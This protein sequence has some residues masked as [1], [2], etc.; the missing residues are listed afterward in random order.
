MKNQFTKSVKKYILR[1]LSRD[2]VNM[3]AQ[4]LQK[5]YEINETNLREN[6]CSVEGGYVIFPVFKQLSGTDELMEKRIQ[7]LSS[8][9]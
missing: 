8:I 5:N 2:Y 1:I 9:T 4:F 7:Q 6:G 3:E